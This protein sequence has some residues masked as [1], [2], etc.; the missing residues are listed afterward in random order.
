M[1]KIIEVKYLDGYRLLCRF[2]SGEWRVYDREP[3]GFNGVW[4]YLEDVNNFKQVELVYGA[5]TWF[6]PN[7]L[8]LDICPDYTFMVSEPYEG[9][10]H[11]TD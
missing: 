9:T 11:E 10:N 5:L 1:K 7:G 3:F 2:K 6:G 8:E 4:A